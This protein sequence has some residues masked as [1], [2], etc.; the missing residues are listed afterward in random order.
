[1]WPWLSLHLRN[2]L[3]CWV[4]RGKFTQDGGGAGSEAKRDGK[5]TMPADFNGK[6]PWLLSP[7]DGCSA[8]LGTS[9]L[10]SSSLSRALHPRA[11]HPGSLR[12]CV[13]AIQ[14][15]PLGIDTPGAFTAGKPSR[16]PVPLC[17]L[18][19]AAFA[20]LR[21][22]P[23]AQVPETRSSGG[24][25]SFTRSISTTSTLSSNEPKQCCPEKG[26]PLLQVTVQ[27]GQQDQGGIK[28]FHA[29]EAGLSTHHVSIPTH[30]QL[31]SH[32]A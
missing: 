25:R 27:W 29:S 31:P 14:S 20:L 18:V 19:P 7:A 22:C 32:W 30:P 11:T 15:H 16:T 26:P 12:Q 28:F 4:E 24:S 17:L 1:M 6:R 21:S 9:A 8:E 10:P 5:S 13:R 3:P 2:T 23:G